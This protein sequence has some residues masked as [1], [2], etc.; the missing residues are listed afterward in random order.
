MARGTPGGSAEGDSR[1]RLRA[2]PERVRGRAMP[3]LQR[4]PG[5]QLL[6]VPAGAARRH[7]RLVVTFHGAGGTAEDGLGILA[8]AADMADLA[9]LAPASTAVTWDAVALG[10][11]ADVAEIDRALAAVLGLLPVRGPLLMAGFSDGATYALSLGLANGDLVGGVMAFSPGFVVPGPRVGRP[12][13]FVAHGVDDGVLPIGS[14][15]RRL[16]PA[17]EADGYAVT[18]REFAGGHEVP[19]AM[20]REGVTAIVPD[21]VPPAR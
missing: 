21:A 8:G 10:F 9:L 11:G 2:R 1:A 4:L 20:V 7:P 14:T 6:Y 16:V 15:S 12:A 19:S 5:G 17:L 18:Y 13:L 3:G